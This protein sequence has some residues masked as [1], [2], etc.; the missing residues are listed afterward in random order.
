MNGCC[1]A[2]CAIGSRVSGSGIVWL[3]FVHHGHRGE[4]KQWDK[5]TKT[6]PH[7]GI[8]RQGVT[9]N[10]CRLYFILLYIVPATETGGLFAVK[11]AVSQKF[12]KASGESFPMKS[13]LQMMLN[14]NMSKQPKMAPYT[15]TSHHFFGLMAK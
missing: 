9:S 12:T 14:A 5:Q 6:S 15:M 13:G 1:C 8:Y 3:I 10:L 7:D 11:K 2:D 4:K